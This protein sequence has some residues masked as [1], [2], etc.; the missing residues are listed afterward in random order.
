MSQLNFNTQF[1]YRPL[2]SGTNAHK[3]LTMPLPV[4]EVVISHSDL[5][6]TRLA[7]IDSG[8]TFSLF[9]R[10][11]ADELEIDVLKGRAEKLMSLG[12]PL[13][14]YHH[15]VNIE[16]TPDFRYHAEILFAEYSIPRNL[17]GH[18]GFFNHLTVGLRS[19]FGL[20]YLNSE[21]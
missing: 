9:S 6:T 8:S 20:I 10:E 21:T 2:L 14:A 12:G 19:R 13:L 1:N 3:T 15:D 11:V 4:I 7:L 18:I 16:I 5:A 17:F